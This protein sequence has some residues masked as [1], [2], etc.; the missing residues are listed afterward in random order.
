[1]CTTQNKNKLCYTAV[2]NIVYPSHVC[3]LLLLLLLHVCVFLCVFM[4]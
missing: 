1:M 2:P 3:T 4:C